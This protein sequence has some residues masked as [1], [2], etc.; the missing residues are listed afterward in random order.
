MDQLNPN[1][2]CQLARRRE[3]PP[4]SARSTQGDDRQEMSLVYRSSCRYLCR[5][6]LVGSEGD[7]CPFR[8]RRRCDVR[9][10]SALCAQ[11]IGAT[12]RIMLRAS[13]LA[14]RASVWNT[15]CARH[16]LRFSALL[17]SVAALVWL[18]FTMTA[19]GFRN[20]DDA[21]NL[22]A[23]VEMAEGNW[24]LHGWIMATD[25]YYPTDVL[26]Q[27]VLYT[28]FGFHPILMQAAEAAIWAV[29][30]F[31]GIRLALLDAP[32]RHLPGIVAIALSLLA[33]N[34]FDHGFR[35]SFLSTIPSHGFTILLTLLAFALFVG[36]GPQRSGLRLAGLGVRGRQRLRSDLHRRRLPADAQRCPA[37]HP[38]RR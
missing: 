31:V 11:Q 13:I 34:Q 19:G 7:D 36:G 22:L 9:A 4:S 8:G 20:S 1:A 38:T 37:W 25:N 10:M 17:M 18:R 29:V 30:A 28:L 15:Q 3:P 2:G 35:D 32:D 5:G 23:G 14:S 27:A 33:F 16:I 24:R 6:R 21:S 12:C 26:T